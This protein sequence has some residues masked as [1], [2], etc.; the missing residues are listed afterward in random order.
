MADQ[1][2]AW[3][4]LHVSTNH[5]EKKRGYELYH[6]SLDAIIVNWLMWWP[7]P[8]V[9]FSLTRCLASEARTVI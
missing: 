1:E 9:K 8:S 5:L 3:A 4:G 6:W 7:L 2:V